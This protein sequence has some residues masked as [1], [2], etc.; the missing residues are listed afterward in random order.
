MVGAFAQSGKSSTIHRTELH[1]FTA[2]CRWSAAKF[3]P[4]S[5]FTTLSIFVHCKSRHERPISSGKID[6]GSAPPSDVV[7]IDPKHLADHWPGKLY[8]VVYRS[9]NHH[10][11]QL[12]V[13]DAQR[14]A[15]AFQ[16]L[17]QKP[18]SL[19]RRPAGHLNILH[20]E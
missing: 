15:G 1:H 13:E 6:T 9:M 8:L 3:K 19:R 16:R 18:N 17:L 7:V 2:V 14:L 11:H 12:T 5:D 20:A 10:W 4:S